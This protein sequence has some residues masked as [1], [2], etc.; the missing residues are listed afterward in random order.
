MQAEVLA[1]DVLRAERALSAGHDHTC[2]VWKIADESQLIC[3]AAGMALDCCRYA[4]RGSPLIN[5]SLPPT[6]SLPSAIRPL[7]PNQHAL[8]PS[9]VTAGRVATH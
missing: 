2:R 6:H 9:G 8:H 7:S 1:L 4:Q 3:R 5:P